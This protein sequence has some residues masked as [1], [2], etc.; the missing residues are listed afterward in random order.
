MQ[1]Q[2][3]IPAGNVTGEAGGVVTGIQQAKGILQEGLYVADRIKAALLTHSVALST[4][5]A[6]AG[7]MGLTQLAKVQ[8]S[9]M[10][11]QETLAATE[12]DLNGRMA[13]LAQLLNTVVAEFSKHL[14][15]VEVRAITGQMP[16]DGAL[17]GN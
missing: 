2:S 13:R 17:T 14:T 9:T 12:A 15:H 3:I 1:A 16:N 7:R 6:S 11:A 5:E 8:Q 10:A 4:L